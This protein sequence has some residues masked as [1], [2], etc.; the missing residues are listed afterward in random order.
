MQLVA[1]QELR[2]ELL[3]KRL[4]HVIPLPRPLEV[5][6]VHLLAA[7]ALGVVLQRRLPASDV[8]HE[9]LDHR[10]GDILDSVYVRGRHVELEE[11][12]SRV[13]REVRTLVAERSP[14]LVNAVKPADDEL[15]Q[16]QLRC[17]P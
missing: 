11:C 13:V 16:V 15:L 6:R 1:R 14:D 9:P 2:P 17:D 10:L 7:L 3:L 4:D 12:R 8:P 5:W